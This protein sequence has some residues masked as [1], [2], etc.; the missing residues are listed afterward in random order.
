MTITEWFKKTGYPNIF[1]AV[2]VVLAVGLPLMVGFYYNIQ[3]I[4]NT[5]NTVNASS[6]KAGYNLAN[7]TFNS[8]FF[9]NETV[10]TFFTFMAMREAPTCNYSINNNI[11]GVLLQANI[12]C[13]DLTGIFNETFY[14][15]SE[16]S[17]VGKVS[18]NFAVRFPYAPNALVV[19]NI[20]IIKT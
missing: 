15:Y 9:E 1:V 11:T 10:F 7:D 12:T 2:L 16:V 8:Y 19:G 17:D 3:V 20:S 14:N 6:F 13:K 5:V 4:P 18:G